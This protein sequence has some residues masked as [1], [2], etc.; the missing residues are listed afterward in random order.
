LPKEGTVHDTNREWFERIV[1]RQ[2]LSVCISAVLIIHTFPKIGSDEIVIVI[3]GV[4]AN[5]TVPDNFEID[6]EIVLYL[7]NNFLISSVHIDEHV[8]KAFV[9]RCSAVNK[10]Y[11]LSAEPYSIVTRCLRICLHDQIITQ[12][13]YL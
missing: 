1:D 11:H 12:I 2:N 5:F 7:R 13:W 3:L 6:V 10:C 8:L 9:S 4:E